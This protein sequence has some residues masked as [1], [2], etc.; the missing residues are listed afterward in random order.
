MARSTTRFARVAAAAL[1]AALVA[2]A[3]PPARADWDSARKFFAE[4]VKNPDWKVRRNAYGALQDHDGA[5][6]A[7]MILVN[8]AVETSRPSSRP[9]W[10]CSGP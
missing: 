2:V 4:N 3:A 1:A 5:P 7:A 9:P 6:A 10:T 8:L